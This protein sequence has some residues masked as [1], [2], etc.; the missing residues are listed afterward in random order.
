L[1]QHPDQDIGQPMSDRA[2]FTVAPLVSVV[3]LLVGA[4]LRMQHESAWQRQTTAAAR[5]RTGTRLL[6]AIALLG[7][8]LGHVVMFAWPN[9]VLRWSR[10]M[11]R[12]MGIE[13]ALLALGAVALVGVADAARR[14]LQR[15]DREATLID[16]ACLGVLLLTLI[17]GLG[18]AVFYRWAAAWS[19][20]TVAR[21]LRAL[22]SL[23]PNLEPLAAMPYLVKLHIFSSFVVVALIAFTRFLDVPLR[24]LLRAS[25]GVIDPLVAA[26]ARHWRP[27]QQR[28]LRSSRR[29]M[30]SEEEDSL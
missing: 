26:G 22:V 12:L 27:V 6:A 8:L 23:Q 24:A 9:E 18:T 5:R 11:S 15:A 30:W 20:V 25:R 13:L 28:L 2:L 17:S 29:L 10:D 7:V 16:A 1:E 3:V 4:T 21:Y 19:A 14:L